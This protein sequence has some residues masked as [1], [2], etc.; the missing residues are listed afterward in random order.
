MKKVLIIMLAIA[1]F[2]SAG[3]YAFAAQ[4]QPEDITLQADSKPLIKDPEPTLKG[5]VDTLDKEQYKATPENIIN[6]EKVKANNGEVKLAEYMLYSDYKN[7]VN[8]EYGLTTLADDR[9]VLAVQIYYPEFEHIRFG[10]IENCLA[11][12]FYDAETGEYLGG[13]YDSVEK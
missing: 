13:K 3:I 2:S 12:G 9:V 5:N 10:V 7:L 6:Y 4:N 11:T 8:D 1:V